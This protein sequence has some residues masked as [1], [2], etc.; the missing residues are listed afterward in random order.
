[1]VYTIIPLYIYIYIYIS[2][3]NVHLYIHTSIIIH[4]SCQPRL[5]QS[6]LPG[7]GPTCAKVLRLHQVIT[8]EHGEIGWKTGQFPP[9]IIGF[10]MVYYWLKI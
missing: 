6:L 9:G 7:L 4:P 8:W 10:I 3:Y 1:M 5:H 2:S